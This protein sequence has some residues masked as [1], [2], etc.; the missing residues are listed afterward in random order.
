VAD[1]DADLVAD[2]DADLV[3]DS[4]GVGMAAGYLHVTG[5]LLRPH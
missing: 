2:S 5:A 3:A 1:S 4:E